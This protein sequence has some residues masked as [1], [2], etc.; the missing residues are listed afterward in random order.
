MLNRQSKQKKS[1]TIFPYWSATIKPKLYLQSNK[2]KDLYK[3]KE[4]KKLI[5][6]SYNE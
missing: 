3:K 5:S 6:L 4:K 2:R 1:K